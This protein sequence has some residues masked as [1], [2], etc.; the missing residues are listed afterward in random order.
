MLILYLD[1]SLGTVRVYHI[2]LRILS[3]ARP[4]ISGNF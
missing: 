2:E 3:L 4:A 1:L